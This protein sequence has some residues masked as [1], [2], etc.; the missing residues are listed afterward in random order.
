MG[1]GAILAARHQ[2][3]SGEALGERRDDARELPG[4]QQ[5]ADRD[6]ERPETIA[7]GV[8]RRFTQSNAS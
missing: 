4:E 2:M 6:H 8:Y 7:I 1:P 3:P 5:Q